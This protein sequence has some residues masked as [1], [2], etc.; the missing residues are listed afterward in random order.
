MQIIY[1]IHEERAKQKL[2]VRQLAE[3]SGVSKSQISD[4]ENG[5]KHPT[6]YVLCLLSLALNVDPCSLFEMSVIA[7]K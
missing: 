6:V 1:K 7:D 4:I 3:K 5:N 2:S